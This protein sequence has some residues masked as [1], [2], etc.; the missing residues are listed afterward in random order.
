MLYVVTIHDA[1]AR[2]MSKS[3]RMSGKA[4][5]TI[6]RSSVVRNSAS[7]QIVNVTHGDR[8]TTLLTFGRTVS[9]IDAVEHSVFQLSTY[10]SRIDDT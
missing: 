9:D 8:S 2:L 6:D 3:A 10:G 5:L 7:E 1:S 4:T